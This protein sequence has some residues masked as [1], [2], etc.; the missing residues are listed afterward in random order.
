MKSKRLYE[1]SNSEYEVNEKDHVN[2]IVGTVVKVTLNWVRDGG[3]ESAKSHWSCHFSLC[4]CLFPVIWVGK[5]TADDL[6]LWG[7]VGGGV[8]GDA[9][10]CFIKTIVGF[11]NGR[12]A[13]YTSFLLK[14][15]IYT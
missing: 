2:V 12:I 10:G 4:V 11:A 1:R 9:D 7:Q 8:G 3:R 13:W 15:S 14:Y 6:C 5:V